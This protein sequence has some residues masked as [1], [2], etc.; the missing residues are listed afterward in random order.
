MLSS[1][2]WT[3]TSIPEGWV[4]SFFSIFISDLDMGLEF[5]LSKFADSTKPGVAADWKDAKGSRYI[6]E[7]GG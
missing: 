1:G 6:G 2:L 7:L 4:Q 3:V 5:I